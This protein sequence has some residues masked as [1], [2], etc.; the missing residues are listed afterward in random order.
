MTAPQL[1]DIEVV[2]A[3][4]HEAWMESK[5]AQGVTSR[6][7]ETGEEL[8]VPYEQL[9]EAAKELDR[10][11]VRAVYEAIQAAAGAE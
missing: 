7:S 4:V 10:G 11:S 6:K 5:R 3:K 2:S 1:P 9:S 8:M